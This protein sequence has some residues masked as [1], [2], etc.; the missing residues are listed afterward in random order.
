MK[1]I[2]TIILLSASLAVSA[3][4][5][6]AA[7]A[8]ASEGFMESVD[9]HIRQENARQLMLLQQQNEIARERRLEEAQIRQ[10]ER[11]ASREI[12]M[13]EAPH[14]AQYEAQETTAQLDARLNAQLD[15]ENKEPHK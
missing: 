1:T 8:G 6:L 3:N 11:R 10:E 4:G 2:L 15:A 5:F 12:A 9:N 14:I 7:M 13:H